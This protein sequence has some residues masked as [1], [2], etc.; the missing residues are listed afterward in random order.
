VGSERFLVNLSRERFR[1]QFPLARIASHM[2]AKENTAPVAGHAVST[3]APNGAAACASDDDEAQRQAELDKFGAVKNGQFQD[4][5][6]RNLTVVGEST[7]KRVRRI[8][9][10]RVYSKGVADYRARVAD[11]VA[12]D[13]AAAAFE[14]GGN[15]GGVSSVFVRARPLFEH[16]AERGEW[17]CV[18]GLHTR[19]VVVHEGCEKTKANEGRVKVLRNHAF[20]QVRHIDTDEGVYSELQYLVQEAAAGRKATLF[21][22]GMTGSGKTYSTNLMFQAAPEELVA[23]GGSVELIAYELVGKRCFDLLGQDGEKREVHLRIGENGATHVQGT[24]ARVAASAQEL[25]ESLREAAAQRETAAT[26]TNASSSRSHAV[27]QMATPEGGTLTVIDLAGNEGTIETAY[28]SKDQMKEAAEINTSLMAL[29]T[30]LAARAKGATHVPY[31]ESVLTRVLRDAFT[32][33]EA[34][35][36]V[37]CCVSPACSHLERTLTTLRSAV[38][39]TGQT[40]PAAPVDEVLREAGVVK[41]GPGTW[42]AEALASWVSQQEFAASVVL[43]EGMNGKQ[44]MKLTAVRLASLCADDR[45]AGKHLFDALRVAAKEAAARDREMRRAFKAGP[46]PGSSMTFSKAAPA[47]PETARR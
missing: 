42:N 19:G 35:T 21:F 45:A 26:G 36:A 14:G 31:R 17:D 11:T 4:A 28:H 15:G 38:Q 20:D 41:G 44:I 16:E 37:L 6:T 3:V 46:K 27:Y 32:N 12:G 34:L 22:Y 8:E 29:R 39:L 18:S 5:V 10:A 43:P 9:S 40:K 25:R 33:Q 24:T 2:A 30:C 7:D 47:K 13:A 23:G 1:A